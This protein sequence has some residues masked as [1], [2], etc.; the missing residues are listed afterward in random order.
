MM[1]KKGVIPRSFAAHGSGSA[2]T[3]RR[4]RRH[5]AFNDGAEVDVYTNNKDSTPRAANHLPEDALY[6]AERFLRTGDLSALPN[7]PLRP[8]EMIEAADV[9]LHAIPTRRVAARSGSL[10]ALSDALRARL[11]V[12]AEAEDGEAAGAALLILTA[13]F[14]ARI[15]NLV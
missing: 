1:A 3:R 9:L 5:V 6:R 12:I 15:H 2:K 14:R 10:P 4:Q 13:D 7:L 8:H 11:R